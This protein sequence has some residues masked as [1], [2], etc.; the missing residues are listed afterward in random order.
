MIVINSYSHIGNE[1]HVWYILS[2]IYMNA[3]CCKYAIFYQLSHINII[4]S[5][6]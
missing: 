3:L 1:N 5:I 6:L 2:N 4:S